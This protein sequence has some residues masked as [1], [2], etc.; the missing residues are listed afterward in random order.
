M[1]SKNSASSSNQIDPSAAS[2]ADQ[3]VDGAA[4]SADA[5]L[6]A[7]SG[8]VQELRQQTAPLFS[9][10]G[11]QAAALAQRGTDVVREGSGQLRDK[12]VRASDSTVAY[13]KDEPIKAVLIAAATGAALMALINLM[14]HSRR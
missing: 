7:L 9:R 10:L 14:S 1:F 6:Q 13:I 12:A 3:G 4:A 8:T 2:V 11:E 5:A